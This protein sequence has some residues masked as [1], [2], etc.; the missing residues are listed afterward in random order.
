M[1]NFS[2]ADN[3]RA[4]HVRKKNRVVIT[5][6]SSRLRSKTYTHTHTHTKVFCLHSCEKYSAVCVCVCVCVPR[7]LAVCSLWGAYTLRIYAC[8]YSPFC[9]WQSYVA[10]VTYCLHFLQKSEVTCSSHCKQIAS[11][12]FHLFF[13]GRNSLGKTASGVGCAE[14]P[15]FSGNQARCSWLGMFKTCRPICTYK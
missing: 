13:H 4:L 10:C 15:E 1:V 12:A 6:Q 2:G 11:N 7:T 3:G 5:Q 8:T 14:F 9:A